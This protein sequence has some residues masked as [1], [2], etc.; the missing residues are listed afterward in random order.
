MVVTT[1]RSNVFF[2]AGSPDPPWAQP[3]ELVWHKRISL[4][5]RGWPRVSSGP[6]SANG[7]ETLEYL[8]LQSAFRCL[9][10]S[11][12]WSPIAI[13]L[14]TLC[15]PASAQRWLPAFQDA[16]IDR[17]FD[18]ENGLQPLWLFHAGATFLDRETE[19]NRILMQNAVD[20][21]EQLNADDFDFGW[22]AGVEAGL[23]RRWWDNDGIELRMI[24]TSELDA[25]ANLTTAVASLQINSSPPVFAPNVSSVSGRYFTKLYSAE[26]NYHHW[27][28]RYASGIIGFRYAAVDD[29]LLVLVD[30]NPLDHRYTATT[31]NDLYGLQVGLLGGPRPCFGWMIVSGTAKVGVFGNDARHRAALDTGAVVLR[32]NDSA[33]N[34]SWMA[35]ANAKAELPITHHLS[36]TGGY[37]VM[38]LDQIAIAT[39][40]LPQSNFFTGTGHSE[41][42]T[43]LFH[44][45]VVAVELRY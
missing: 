39:D 25:T 3:S 23:V 38:W 31:R 26:A 4:S 10:N 40:Q 14:M 22:T 17:R 2:G 18:V 9:L 11:L 33:D 20:P 42:G 21:S 29:D 45:G 8:R 41:R 6:R 19:D 28:G 44:G 7:W 36:I 27:L 24:H 15:A 30:S 37:T 5:S 12:R 35:E 43:A 34:L 1:A 32:I 13:I 16:Q